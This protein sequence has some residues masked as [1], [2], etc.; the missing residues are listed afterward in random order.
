[1]TDRIRISSM[2]SGFSSGAI[3][4][5]REVSRQLNHEILNETFETKLVFVRRKID[6][7]PVTVFLEH[8]DG[9]GSAMAAEF[10]ED[11]SIEGLVQDGEL[12]IDKTE[13]LI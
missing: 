13:V 6:G 9:E 8:G 12:Y 7:R 3:A 10:V 4:Q 11:C 1:M 5:I 2:D